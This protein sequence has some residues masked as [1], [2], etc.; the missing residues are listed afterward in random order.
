MKCRKKLKTNIKKV[1][2]LNWS[3]CGRVAIALVISFSSLAQKKQMVQ[4][5][6]F[7]QQLTPSRNAEV[8][9]NNKEYFSVGNKGTAFIELLEDDFPLKS[10]KI[11]DEKFEAASWNFSKG[12]LE[13]IIRVKN[14]QL[15][16]VVVR[17]GNN[18]PLTNLTVTFAGRKTTTATTGA[19]GSFDIPLALDEKINA[20]EQFTVAGFNPVKLQSVNGQMILTLNAVK[21]VA[22]VVQAPVTTRTYFK[23]FD[24]S[25]LDSIQSL[26][27]F[28]A[29]F[30]NFPIKE[31]SEE[32]K[33]KIDAKFN[34]LVAQLQDSVYR[35]NSR[36]MGKISDS[37]FVSDD[38]GNLLSQ[39]QQEGRT[40]DTQRAEFEEKIRIIQEKLASGI[41]TM[42]EGTR[43]NLLSDLT[44]LE[45]LLSSNESQFFKNQNDYRDIIN[46]IKEKY[47]DITE[48][49]GK[50]SKSEEQ[51]LV[52]QRM[53][54]QKL[55]ITLGI[56]L[57]FGVLIILLIYFGD[58][59]K[60]QKKE[61]VL[62]NEEIKT[63]NE[64][65]ESIVT[66]RTKLLEAT[67]KELDTFLY[68]AS[69]DLRSPVCSIIGLCNIALQTSGEESK[70][71]MQRVVL[72]TGTMDRLLKKL[73]IISE[74]NQP[75]DF[76]SINLLDLADSVGNSFS[77]V[78]REQH[79]K[80]NI[81]CAADLVF[82]SYPNLV[83][84]ILTNLIENAL[85][86]SVMKD[87][88]NAHVDVNAEIKGNAVEIS[89]YD[90]GIGIDP[91]ITH[92][93]FD[94][95]FKGTEKSKGSG[96]GLYIVQKSVQALDGK[97][98]IES[99]VG[100]FSKFTVQFPMKPITFEADPKY[101]ID[102]TEF[103]VNK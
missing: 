19:S 52:D 10:V 71:L 95:F 57:V 88:D 3:F 56:L 62:V 65:L 34:Q 41:S 92:R 31:M 21:P 48:L 91:S 50:L 93:L 38:M 80:L 49:E 76:S 69:H 60:K 2:I 23:D 97:I 58:R 15:A 13:V 67:N 73:A 47:F 35:G 8:S 5:K 39:A 74:I 68:R 43:A 40:L 81:N 37:S 24:L 46:S 64:N 20:P 53:F 83:A 36:F 70:D 32:A 72:T 102:L 79:I 17:D 87:P 103:E 82:H 63:I 98:K 11:K 59:L 55:F 42:D 75:T 16:R 1:R 4:V 77:H 101:K 18:A 89:V 6:V 86:F 85:F 100:G 61:L 96:L 51:R 9:I 26:T 12:I 44:R 30:K 84:T 45:M 7:D 28:Y 29:I 78:V 99:E 14:Y 33:R 22:P 25:K 94:M 90:N 27:V 54:R 66:E